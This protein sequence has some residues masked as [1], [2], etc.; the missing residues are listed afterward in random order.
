[1]LSFFLRVKQTICAALYNRRNWEIAF[2]GILA[3]ATVLLAIIAFRTDSALHESAK[4]HN[5]SNKLNAVGLRP[6]V[7]SSK[8]VIVS[9]LTQ[10]QN[11]VLHMSLQHDITN[12]GHSPALD[13]LF[14][15][16]AIPFNIEHGRW[17]PNNLGRTIPGIDPVAEL[18]R[19]C[20]A[21][22][23]PQSPF[24]GMGNLLFP[25]QS[26]DPATTD[27]NTPNTRFEEARKGVSAT[28]ITFMYVAT[29]IRYRSTMDSDVH[30]TGVLYIV[31]RGDDLNT[32]IYPIDPPG[33]PRAQLHIFAPPIGGS[34]AT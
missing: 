15:A 10:D 33:I 22:G 26:G 19:F 2:A 23:E 17:M 16:T 12:T 18:R 28:T 13:A 21:Q 5:D 32:S 6:W 1:L 25:N 24:S 4:A 8:P 11:G 3:F 20:H 7:S 14:L 34:Y 31:M 9:D 27:I 29:C 30:E